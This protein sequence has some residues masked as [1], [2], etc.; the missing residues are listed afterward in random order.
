MRD[1]AKI[2]FLS[3]MAGAMVISYRLL[4]NAPLN[5][6]RAHAPTRS[7]AFSIEKGGG[8]GLAPKA[9]LI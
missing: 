4:V 2:R 7:G 1:V 9:L 6:C 3:V 5:F 8:M